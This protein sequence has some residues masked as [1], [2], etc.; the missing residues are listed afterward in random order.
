MATKVELD[1][2]PSFEIMY[3]LF[4]VISSKGLRKHQII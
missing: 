2:Q 1:I 3:K 4:E